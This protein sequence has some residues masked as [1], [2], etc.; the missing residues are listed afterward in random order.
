MRVQGHLAAV[1]LLGESLDTMTLVFAILVGRARGTYGIKA[2]ATTGN[3]QFERY[4]RVQMNTLEL[5]VV[6]LPALWLAATY[7]SP[8]I[9]AGIGAVYLV[10]RVLYFREYIQQPTSRT[11]GFSLSFL[12]ILALLIAALAGIIRS[13]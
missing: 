8:A 13:L 7:W 9:M 5:L 1:P 3:E 4:Y 10:G 12:P 6:L 2:P 11:L